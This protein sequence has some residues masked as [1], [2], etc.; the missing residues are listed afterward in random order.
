MSKLKKEELI[1]D[2]LFVLHTWKRHYPHKI[3][4]NRFMRIWENFQQIVARIK[5]PEIN[6]DWLPTPENINAL[7]EPIRKFIHD[8]E[9]N[10]DPAHLVRENLLIKDSCKAL[11]LKLEQ[12]IEVDIEM[13]G[14]ELFGWSA[15]PRTIK[16]CE[17]FIRSFIEEVQGK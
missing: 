7:P 9:T 5:K 8:I 14:R 2:V 4:P 10:C 3:R 13:K 15:E 11:A 1:Q 17:D 16:E 12:K 6:E